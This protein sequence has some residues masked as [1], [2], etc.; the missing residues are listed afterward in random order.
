M[1]RAHPFQKCATP[2]HYTDG[3]D[4]LPN[5]ENCFVCG[6]RNAAGLSVRFQR[7]GERVRTFFTPRDSQMGYKGITHGGV[8]S[9]LLDE[10]MGWAP[11]L[12]NRRFCM[13]VD[14]HVRFLKPLPIGTEVI[15]EGWVTVA[16]RRIWE[17]AG[18]IRD[19]TGPVYAK[20]TGRYIP[21]SEEQTLEV[22]R[23]LT[24]DEGATLWTEE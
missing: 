19:S 24:F 21:L 13:S 3:M 6:H 7:D 10:T 22:T 16:N 8:L 5:Y 17:T 11:A 23:Y 18:E 1:R 12:K 15:V 2:S 9:A 14:L 4:K 20:A